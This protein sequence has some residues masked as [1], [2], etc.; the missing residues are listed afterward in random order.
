MILHNYDLFENCYRVRLVASCAEVA[1]ELIN[2]D[3]FPG[4]E[5]KS[6]EYLKLN[7]MGRLPILED[8]ALVLRNLSA[9]LIYVAEHDIDKRFIPDEAKDRAQMM[10]WLG[11]ACDDLA[12]AVQA[13][14]VALLDATGDVV[15]LRAQARTLFRILDDHLTRQSLRGANFVAGDAPSLADL[16]LFPAF[17]L[18]RDFN[19]DHDE[20][21]ALRL[22]A[23]RIRLLPGFITMPGIPDYH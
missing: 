4:A 20:F 8:N 12:V 17:A 5:E 6:P 16:A 11:F 14:A 22:W 13:R 18:S 1:L 9:I 19:L 10:D 21:P 15:E 23:R 3:A 2:V 7:P